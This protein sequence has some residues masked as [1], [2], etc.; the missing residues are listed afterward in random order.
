MIT[1]L[2]L[3][4]SGITDMNDINGAAARNIL[5]T[6]AGGGLGRDLSLYFERRGHK[7]LLLDSHADSLA[8]TVMQLA[9][10]ANCL[11]DDVVD[12]TS[13]AQVRAFV[14]RCGDTRMD[15]LVNNAGTQHVLSIEDL[16][17]EK[18][19]QLLDVMLKGPFLLSQAVLPRMRANEFGRIVNIG[20]IHSLVASPFK[21]AYVAAKHGLLG[22]A[23]VAAL[24]TASVDITVNTICPSYIKTPLVDAQVKAQ[25]ELYGIPEGEVISRIMLEPMPKKVFI[26]PD[27]VAATIEF[28]MTHE[29]RNITG[30][31][32]VIDGGWTS[33]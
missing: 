13:A 28:L 22:L 5:I 30:Q 20:S 3:G 16:P 10:P 11:L 2:G 15:V 23:K 32:I 7:L 21:S 17:V 12:I 4:K 26:T 14:D 31:T 1:G 24:E 27:E 25:A 33:R 9:S 19:D 29:A 8:E 6:G 18:W